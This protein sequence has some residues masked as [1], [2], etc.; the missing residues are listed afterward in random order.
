MRTPSK[1]WLV[2]SMVAAMSLGGCG[3]EASDIDDPEASG[4]VD[5]L[6]ASGDVDHLEASA[7]ALK[8]TRVRRT[9]T[10]SEG[11]FRGGPPVFLR[12]RQ[13]SGFSGSIVNLTEYFKPVK[14]DSSPLKSIKATY[15]RTRQSRTTVDCRMR[16]RA[17]DGIVL[18]QCPGVAGPADSIHLTILRRSA[19]TLVRADLGLRGLKVF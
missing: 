12:S 17:D 15:V 18:F 14:F 8:K 1:L 4:D 6:E 10:F 9:L 5:D 16:Y 11:S 19:N 2:C 7:D 13:V 3:V